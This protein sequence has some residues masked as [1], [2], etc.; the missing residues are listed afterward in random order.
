MVVVGAGICGLLAAHRL[1]QAGHDVV[2]VEAKDRVGGRLENVEIDG[3][4]GKILELG[5]QWFGE[6]QDELLALARELEC[7]WFE[8][9]VEGDALLHRAGRTER[10]AFSEDAES[11]SPGAPL[12][13]E[14]QAEF[15][16]VVK[17]I[18]Q[19]SA[20]VPPDAPWDAPEADAWDSITFQSWIEQQVGGDAA[21]VQVFRR[22]FAFYQV[23]L[24]N[25][26]S[27]LNILHYIASIGSFE[28]LQTAEQ[29]QFTGGFLALCDRLAER[30]GDRVKLGTP[31]ASIDQTGDRVVVTA[32]DGST[33]AGRECVVAM[34]PFDA[35]FIEFTPALPGR[36]DYVHRNYQTV[37]VIK[38]FAVYDEPF[39]RSEGLSGIVYSD[40]PVATF[41][42][43]SSPA[44]GDPGVLMTY[45]STPGD[46]EWSISDE[47]DADPDARR[48]AVLESFA[49]YF[50]PRAARPKQYIERDW[51]DVPYSAGVITTMPPGFLTRAAHGMKDPVGRIHWCHAE[52]ASHWGLGVWVNGGVEY[53]DRTAAAVGARLGT[54]A[55]A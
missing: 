23:S 53:A 4:P 30:L 25:R 47:L 41:A 52:L 51:H 9:Y 19:L 20:E 24:I 35:R 16:R 50:G 28:L 22:Y 27:L 11:F 18:E 36:R 44:G 38:V 8:V 7:S 48:E 43:D 45:L 14:Q 29:Y 26:Y 2:V 5:G 39:W 55:G 33:F 17:L 1:T 54:P 21:M 34:A 32:K 12:P 37:N 42:L 49:A 3:H 31:V 10:F 13:P 15:D 40:R 46:G 6:G